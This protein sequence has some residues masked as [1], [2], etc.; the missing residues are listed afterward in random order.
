MLLWNFEYLVTF[1]ATSFIEEHILEGLRDLMTNLTQW[2]CS[3]N[4]ASLYEDVLI[5]T[6]R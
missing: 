6:L 1:F 4:H 2:K 3:E 5:S